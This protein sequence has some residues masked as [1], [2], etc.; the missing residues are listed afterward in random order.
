MGRWF[1]VV[2]NICLER[3][4]TGA[5]FG[6]GR[7]FQHTHARNMSKFIYVATLLLLISWCHASTDDD[8]SSESSDDSPKASETT[9]SKAGE[10]IK[11]LLQEK[12]TQKIK[13]AANEDKGVL[14]KQLGDSLKSAHEAF[15]PP[16]D[17]EKKIQ[18]AIGAKATSSGSS[19]KNANGSGTYRLKTGRKMHGTAQAETYDADAQTQGTENY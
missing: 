3:W 10:A 14:V 16:K 5:S 6:S 17:K 1:E 15:N 2:Q 4:D 7:K 13:E 8:S 11:T 19:S 9:E 18:E 12:I